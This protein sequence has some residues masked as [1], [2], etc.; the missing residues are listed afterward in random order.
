MVFALLV[1]SAILMKLANVVMLVLDDFRTT[2]NQTIL[3]TGQM[4][5][6]CKTLMHFLH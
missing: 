3:P 5:S 1:A 4:P 6:S 2:A